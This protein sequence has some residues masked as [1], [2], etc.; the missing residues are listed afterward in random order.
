MEERIN[1]P[2]NP[3][4]E[5]SCN[6]VDDRI[7]FV[8][9]SSIDV[10][11][12]Y[13]FLVLYFNSSNCLEG[14]D[15][16]NI[17]INSQEN[18]HL[19][20][21]QLE[22]AHT[23][24]TTKHEGLLKG[25]RRA[26]EE[27]IKNLRVFDDPQIMV[28]QVKK[29]IHYSSPHIV[30]YQHEVWSLNGNLD[31]F[32]VTYIPRKYNHDVDLMAAMAVKLLP[33]IRL[34]KN[35]FYGELIFRSSVTDNILNW[36]VFEGDNQILEFM[37]CERTP[38]NTAINKREQDKLINKSEHK[39]ISFID[40]FIYFSSLMSEPTGKHTKLQHSWLSSFHVVEKIGHRIYTLKTIQ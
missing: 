9:N 39:V 19:M 5:L 22:S 15:A 35:K 1:H 25:L 37:R 32:N 3:T 31:S 27:N 21:D 11:L 26:I 14:A 28:N 17:L 8:D 36:Q 10:A 13:T 33:N 38:R 20:A 16:L 7:N 34:N 18:Q 12:D 29:R 30:R 4:N 24:N 23:R 40:K 2:H 6:I